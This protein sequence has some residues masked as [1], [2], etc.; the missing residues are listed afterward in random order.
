MT[1]TSAIKLTDVQWTVLQDAKAGHVYRL[2]Y[3]VNLY[4]SYDRAQGRNVRGKK[5]TAIVD[6]LNV[7]GLLR[8]DKQSG[9]RWVWHV[10]EKGEQALAQKDNAS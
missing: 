1:E 6:R 10:T 5:V 7:L 3:G 4:E 9:I 2:Y 8:I